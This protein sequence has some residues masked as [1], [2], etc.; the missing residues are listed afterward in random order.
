MTD[1]LDQA[2]KE[3]DDARRKVQDHSLDGGA[4]FN[5][6]ER[7]TRRYILLSEKE[8]E[9]VSLTP[10]WDK[11]G[12]KEAQ[13]FIGRSR[14]WIDK[15]VIQKIIITRRDG[16]ITQFCSIN[17]SPHINKAKLKIAV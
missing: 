15:R 2:K 13:E 12:Y 3:V 1:K 6:L 8:Q 16:N 14:D 11:N 9:K 5:E 4:L 10:L 17:L 7:T